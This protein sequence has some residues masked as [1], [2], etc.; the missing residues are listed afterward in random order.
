MQS[1]PAVADLNGVS[2][3]IEQTPAPVGGSPS[4]TRGIRVTFGD[5]RSGLEARG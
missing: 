1:G 4:H 3:G 5:D 2:F